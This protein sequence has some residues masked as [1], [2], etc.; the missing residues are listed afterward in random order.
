M[1]AVILRGKGYQHS[2]NACAQL[3]YTAM[4]YANWLEGDLNNPQDVVGKE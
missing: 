4:L 1:A 2:N 3:H